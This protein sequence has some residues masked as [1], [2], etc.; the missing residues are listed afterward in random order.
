[1][2][3]QQEG[4][5]K[6][7]EV[8]EKEEMGRQHRWK[9]M[10]NQM[11]SQEVLW[12]VGTHQLQYPFVRLMYCRLWWVRAQ[13]KDHFH[14]PAQPS[15]LVQWFVV[16]FQAQSLSIQTSTSFQA[17]HHVRPRPSF[18]QWQQR[19][20]YHVHSFSSSLLSSACPSSPSPTSAPGISDR[21]LPPAL[22]GTV[23]SVGPHSSCSSR[24][25]APASCVR[26]PN[27]SRSVSNES[28]GWLVR[29]TCHSLSDVVRTLFVGVQ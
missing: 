27:G 11:E 23:S 28:R 25:C 2:E 29:S 20:G 16:R 4:K 10:A 9:W 1:M 21:W 19:H 5:V 15:S 17:P 24:V 8:V 18:H 26:H 14:W 6:V 12:R 13:Q 22:Q 3:G 7:D